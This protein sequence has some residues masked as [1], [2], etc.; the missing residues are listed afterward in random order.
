M[1]K[2]KLMM[3]VSPLMG[4]LTQALELAKLMLARNNQLSITAL[5]MELP[6][7]PD[8]TAKIQ[9]LIAA[10][11]VEGL[12]F[13][14]LSTPEDTSDWNI[15]HRRF[16]I[17]KLLEYQKPHVREIASKTQ[18]L[19]GFLIDLINMTMIDVADELGVPTYLFFTSGAAFLGLRFHFQTLE[20][21]QNQ[22]TSELVKGESHL[23]LPSFAKPVPISVLPTLATKEEFRSNVFLKC[24]RDYR[25]AKGII[26]NTFS[27]LESNAISSFSLN[28]YYGKS[29]LPPIYPVGPI[30]NSSQ[31]QTQSSEDY[32]SM[33]KWLDC[34]P[35]NSVVFLC[36]GSLGSF[37]LDQVQEIAY[38]IE[39][40]GHRF[41]WVLRRPSTKKGGFPREYENLELVLPEGF[42]DR[43]ASIGK[44]VGWVPQLAVL[45]HSA[46]GGFV[47]HC[48]WNSMLESIFFG[49]PIATWPIEAEQQLNAFQLVKELGIAVEISLDYNQEK[50]NQALVKAEQVEKG[51]REIM[52]CEN[53]VRM[54]VKEFSEKS[55]LTTKEGGSS[56]LALD[57]IIQDICSR[58]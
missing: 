46:V 19:S 4:H 33:M 38:G 11:N 17:L 35:K 12:H 40:S 43:T 26:V 39:R 5:I 41:L 32:S 50:E 49:V 57:N 54:R 15:T 20:D 47:S 29:S 25:R 37:H 42:L 45:S 58:S 51:I 3:M 10:T 44:V 23:V 18:K 2:F 9:S 24:T 6:I 22:D 7:D 21:E 16:F 56:Y 55:R 30:L 27:Y 36:F 48:G 53:E 28:S 8:G 14:H 1:E 34:Q 52:D 13:H 31:I